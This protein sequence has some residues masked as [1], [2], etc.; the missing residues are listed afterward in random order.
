[1]RILVEMLKKRVGSPLSYRSLSEGLQVSPN[2]GERYIDILSA[3][4]I[5]RVDGKIACFE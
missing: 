4:F 5:R 3:L 1:M 2:T